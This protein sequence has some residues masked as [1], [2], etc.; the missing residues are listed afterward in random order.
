MPGKNFSLDQIYQFVKTKQAQIILDFNHDAAKQASSVILK[1]GTGNTSDRSNGFVQ[2]GFVYWLEDSTGVWTKAQWS[3]EASMGAGNLLGLALGKFG[4]Y[5]GSPETVGMLINGVATTAVFGDADIGA[6]LWGSYNAAG[7]LSAAPPTADGTRIFQKVG[8]SLG[9][10][11]TYLDGV[12]YVETIVSF[13]PSLEFATGSI[14]AGGGG[15]GGGSPGGSTTQ[16]Q[17]NSGGSFG[18]SSNLTFDGTTLTGSFTGSL[19][20]FT[21]LSASNATIYGDLT[22]TGNDIRGSGG[23][24]IT[25]DGSNN[26]TFASDITVEGSSAVIKNGS[27]TATISIDSGGDVTITPSVTGGRI[28]LNFDAI[29][30]RDGG[31]IERVEGESSLVGAD[32]LRG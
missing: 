28:K 18:G 32:V 25:M 9:N 1:Y 2:G 17:Y 13:T 6:P 30:D 4:E 5:E 19:A 7:R 11:L 29:E 24:A 31:V 23:T 12:P 15:G 3:D 14:G 16:V 21:T 10:Q 22:V 26:V 27:N 20:E 8:H